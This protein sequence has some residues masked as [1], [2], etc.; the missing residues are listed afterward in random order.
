MGNS[1]SNGRCLTG[2][3]GFQLEASFSFSPAETLL[4]DEF[5]S[6]RFAPGVLTGAR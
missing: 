4:L 3:D 1:N 5:F 6:V 2:E